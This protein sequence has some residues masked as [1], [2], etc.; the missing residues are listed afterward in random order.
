MA[1]V[2]VVLG[3]AA[4]WYG[5]GGG[6]Y[7]SPKATF[8]T[9]HTAAKAGNRDGV[10]NSFDE[11]SRKNLMEIEKIINEAAKD[12]PELKKEFGGDIVA[13]L[14]EEMKKHEPKYGEEKITGETAT[15]KVTMDKKE[16]EIPFVRER[17]AWKM[18]L[19]GE[20]PSP[21]KMREMVKMMKAMMQGTKGK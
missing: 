3:L 5:C 16:D 19:P 12:V 14:S 8:Q 4:C 20:M 17:G 1:V 11:A 7:S 2:L 15:L 6:D 10:L 21:E 13:K 9:M 18:K